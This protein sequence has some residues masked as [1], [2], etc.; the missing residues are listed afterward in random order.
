MSA[1]SLVTRMTSGRR[2]TLVLAAVAS[3]L[4]VSLVPFGTGVRAAHADGTPPMNELVSVGLNGVMPNGEADRPQI[5]KD[6]RYVVFDSLATNLSTDP[7]RVNVRNIYR[8][9]L[10]TQ[11]TRVVSIG[12]GGSSSDNWS[13]YAWTSGDG[14]YVAFASDASNLTSGGV[15]R[16]SVFVRDM[17]L[18]V[19]ERISVTNAG[20][21]A[22]LASTRPMMTPNGRY[23]LYN[24]QATN[25]AAQAT[26]QK[27]QIYVRDRQLGTTTLVSV[28][29]TGTG[30]GNGLSYRGM[31]SD[32]GRYVVWAARATNLVP[33]DTNNAEDIFLRDM[34][35]GVTTR[36]DTTPGGA[37]VTSG[38]SRP[39]LSPDGRY[40]TYNSYAAALDPTD[41]GTK[42]DVYLYDV[43]TATSTRVSKGLNGADG[44][45]DALRGFVTDNGRYVVFNSFSSNLVRNDT[46]STGDCFMRD[47]TTGVT[48]RISLPSYGGNANGQTFRP[49][50]S[51]DGGVVTYKGLARN[52]VGGDTSKG[53]QIY[54]VRPLGLAPGGD[55]TA[56]QA[57]VDTP[58]QSSTVQNRGVTITGSATDDVA[59][60]IVQARIRDTVSGQYLQPDGSFGAAN[61]PLTADLGARWTSSTTWALHVTL[62]NGSYGASVTTTDTN[63]NQNAVRPYRNFKVNAPPDA[64]APAATA[65]APADSVTVTTRAVT[66]SGQ[67]TDDGGAGA[68]V[69]TVALSVQNPADGTWLQPNGSWGAAQAALPTTLANRGAVSTD[70]SSTLTLPDGSYAYTVLPTDNSGNVG[71]ATTLTPFVVN[72]PDPDTTKP[73]A[74]FTSPADGVVSSTSKVQLAG[75]ATDPAGDLAGI[76]SVDVR[77]R[78][79]STGL[80][81][82]DEGDFAPP[83]TRLS[84]SLAQPGALST[85]WTFDADLPTGSYTVTWYATDLAGNE[86]LGIA[87][88]TVQVDNSDK[89]KPTV[90]LT[91]PAAGSTVAS[92]PVT[93]AGDAADTGGELAGVDQVLVVVHNAVTNKYLQSN[94]TW[95]NTSR[96]LPAQ[97]SAPAQASTGWTFT[98]SLA[99]GSYDVAYVALDISKNESDAQSAIPFTVS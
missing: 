57:T 89:V 54:V 82:Q 51:A 93:L 84:A 26:N 28:A 21:P 3:S 52:L 29:G 88:R 13:S 44:T 98:T 42:S 58:A 33:N 18:G 14:R 4:L 79:T 20:L 67:A 69:S 75:D 25:L 31:G 99:T 73:T 95:G 65:S 41:L 27:D 55:A 85:G 15:G 61:T 12:L 72:G 40:I 23:V 35:T 90:T 17:D 38:G 45:G 19:T 34:T 11:Q 86:S 6:G 87:G 62:P 5:S 22:N 70:W 94:G 47:L 1:T 16:R 63:K 46:N 53:W 32:D 97:L 74:T 7:V 30:V 39:Y 78:Q 48:T 96:R 24:S 9:D 68:G 83:A 77:I 10:L 8:R 91:S 49:V 80:Y 66:F 81:Q 2:R 92:G 59:I 36:V 50:P 64:V 56:P 43:T 37:Q 71:P 60:D 76:A